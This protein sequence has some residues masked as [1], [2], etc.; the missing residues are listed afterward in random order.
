MVIGH[1]E[2]DKKWGGAI[3]YLIILASQK[4]TVLYHTRND[5][6]DLFIDPTRLDR[7]MIRPQSLKTI[8]IMK[9]FEFQ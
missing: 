3:K 4:A 9:V 5:N 2:W 7:S 8:Q 6:T 1:D